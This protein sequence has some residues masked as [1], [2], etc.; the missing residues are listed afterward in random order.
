MSGGQGNV[1]TGSA[2][3][4]GGGI[5]N[6]TVIGSG[7]GTIAGGN[8]NSVSGFA[9][10]IGGGVSNTASGDRATISGGKSN[11]ASNAYTTIAGGAA[12]LAKSYGQS[13]HAAGSFDAN[14][15]TAQA[16]EYVFRVLTTDATPTTMGLDGGSVG[17]TFEAGHRRWDPVA[18]TN[19]RAFQM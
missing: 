1:A 7:Y 18:R 13:A 16:S 3:V 19:D 8:L 4:I 9:G 11:V 10:T 17:L 5:S 14:A 6:T 2:S 15:G 12:G